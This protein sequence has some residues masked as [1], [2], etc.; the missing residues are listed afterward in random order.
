MRCMLCLHAYTH[1][2][3]TLLPPACMGHAQHTQGSNLNLQCCWV[4]CVL[5]VPCDGSP[6]SS[7][8]EPSQPAPFPP[9]GAIRW[10][11]RQV[12][13]PHAPQTRPCTCKRCARICYI[14]TNTHTNCMNTRATETHAHQH[15][16]M[17]TYMHPGTHSQGGEQSWR[18][19]FTSQLPN[20]GMEDGWRCPWGWWQSQAGCAVQAVRD[21]HCPVGSRGRQQAQS[22][23]SLRQGPIEAI[24]L[25]G[26]CVNAPTKPWPPGKPHGAQAGAG[27]QVLAHPCLSSGCR[28]QLMQGTEESVGAGGQGTGG[29][30]SVPNP[31]A[32]SSHPHPHPLVLCPSR[33]CEAEEGLEP[34]HGKW[35]LS[36]TAV[37]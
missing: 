20:V 3:S 7:L 35:L 31:R 4:L 2:H 5:W 30:H 23:P 26:A 34:A 24:R 8:C 10:A 27:L 17:N 18:S 36:P 32:S 21:T 11:N 14:G 37:P 1:K 28:R 15:A 6:L 29:G 25:M 19:T 16:H 12:Q 13:S 22:S 9:S 33:S